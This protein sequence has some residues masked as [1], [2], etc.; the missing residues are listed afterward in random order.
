MNNKCINLRVRTKKGIKYFYCK[1]YCKEITLSCCRECVNKEYKQYKSL[2]K[3]TNKQSRREKERYSIIYPNLSKCCI[4]GSYNAINK[5]ECIYGK[6]RSN[7][8]KYGLVVPLCQ[9]HHTGD[10]GVHH[11][12]DLDIY[13]HKLAQMYFEKNHTREEF[14]NIFKENY[15]K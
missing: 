3:R 9:D 6:N 7:S 8:I 10:D 2:N 12:K 14:I 15:L 5:H 13:F 4:C 11:N 1:L